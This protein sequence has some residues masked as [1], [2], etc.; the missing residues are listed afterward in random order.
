MTFQHSLG[1]HT[2]FLARENIAYLKEWIIYHALL[3]VQHFYLYDNTGSS[4]RDGSNST[5][6][7]YGINFFE[8]TK[9]MTDDDIADQMDKIIEDVSVDVTLIK[10]QP[11]DKHGQIYYGYNESVCHC[12]RT[13]G[14]QTEWMLFID[15][16]EFLFSPSSIDVREE[17]S[18]LRR[19][20]CNRLIILQKKFLDRFLSPS[21]YVTDI[22]D[23]IEGIDTSAWAPKNIV[24]VD[25]L[26]LGALESMHSM[27]VTGKTLKAETT[28]IRFN[29]YN[30]NPA[31]LQWMKWFYQTT[32]EFKI[33][34]RDDGMKRSQQRLHNECRL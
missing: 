28:A 8:L 2:V 4:G 30:V 18:D 7:K 27:P 15:V 19:T 14:K 20:G 12:I 21:K 33:G 10:W 26:I 5:T 32:A 25:D 6:N 9:N 11:R 16:D 34:A 24:H 31:Q 13:Y 22:Y 29:H 17:L 1:I 23:C 3:G